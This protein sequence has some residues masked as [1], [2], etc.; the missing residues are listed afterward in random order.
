MSPDSDIEEDPTEGR[1]QRE[2]N[3][4]AATKCRAKNKRAISELEESSR[5]VTEQREFLSAYAASL[6]NEVLALKNELLRHGD[7]DCVLIQTYLSSMARKVGQGAA[8]SGP[9]PVPLTPV[10]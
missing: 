8:G 3:R 6:K 1:S 5:V 10:V 2:R 7:C 4:A 9:T